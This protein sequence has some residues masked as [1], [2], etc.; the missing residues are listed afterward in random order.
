MAATAIG[1][2]KNGSRLNQALQWSKLEVTMAMLG[3]Y[4]YL[5]TLCHGWLL[6]A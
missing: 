2:K 4:F 1:D 6:T 5:Y 3:S